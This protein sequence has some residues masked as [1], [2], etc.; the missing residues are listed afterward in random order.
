MHK[1]N[2]FANS[3]EVLILE[4]NIIVSSLMQIVSRLQLPNIR[5]MDLNLNQIEWEE[6]EVRNNHF[7]IVRKIREKKN[8]NEKISKIRSVEIALTRELIIKVMSPEDLFK[9]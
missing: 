8:I 2:V 6:D 3:L 5:Y 9:D 1:G 4:R 7:K